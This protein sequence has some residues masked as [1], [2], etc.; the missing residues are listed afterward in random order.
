MPVVDA[1]VWVAINHAA[2]P[3]HPR[4]IGWLEAAR[5]SG[6]R[7][8]AP[9]L[10]VAEVA[11]AVRR[12]TGQETLASEV[13]EKLLTLGVL[14]LISLDLERSRRASALAAATGVRGADALYLALAQE[15]GDV[16][17]TID[18]Q[19]CERGGAIVEIRQP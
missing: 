14:D 5:A 17:V 1:S 7:L 4:C 8:L 2:D 12:L 18:R 9:T 13:V 10:L 16:L 6:E 11:A 15:R 3:A 19:Q